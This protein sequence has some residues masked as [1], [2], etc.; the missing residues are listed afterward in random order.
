MAAPGLKKTPASGCGTV[1]ATGVGS[2]KK[3]RSMI[4]H[5]E[6]SPALKEHNILTF[7]LRG[8]VD[9][10]SFINTMRKVIIEMESA[11]K[12]NL[13]VEVDSLEGVE[14]DVLWEGLKFA[15]TSLGEYLSHIEKVALITNQD[16]LGYLARLEDKMLPGIDERVFSFSEKEA[17]L[18][19]LKSD[20]R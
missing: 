6:E 10:V 13:Y 16:W 2:I 11:D 1:F 3:L 5:I 12:L 7:R 14:L 17:A 8:K 9:K 18:A 15:F 4:E 20:Q 19:W